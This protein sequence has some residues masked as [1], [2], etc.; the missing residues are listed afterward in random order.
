VTIPEHKKTAKITVHLIDDSTHEGTEVFYVKLKSH[1]VKLTPRKVTVAIADDDQGPPTPPAPQGDVLAGTVVFHVHEDAST[2]D[3]E[4]GSPGQEQWLTT[5]EL[6]LSL[7]KGADGA[8]YDDGTGYWTYESDNV[9]W[10]RRGEGI[11][12]EDN[13]FPY[14][15]ADEAAVGHLY[16]K[17]DWYGTDGYNK[18]PFLPTVAAPALHQAYV[19]LTGYHPDGSGTP[20]LEVGA[21]LRQDRF[22][23]R[24]ADGAH[25]CDPDTVEHPNPLV[26]TGDDPHLF[27]T[28]LYKPLIP[29]TGAPAGLTAAYA[30][31]GLDFSAGDVQVDDYGFYNDDTG[32][33]SHE[34]TYHYTV[35][36]SLSLH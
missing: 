14:A 4:L 20:L 3:L 21:H 15:C 1:A 36:G 24:I 27:E 26:F 32:H 11:D 12:T 8:W 16:K 18:G 13:G 22:E 30:G 17:V 9:W 2:S 25:V 19:K 23:T 6:H 5:M 35:T 29:G 10:F 28:D 34:E 33:W 31:S 7:R